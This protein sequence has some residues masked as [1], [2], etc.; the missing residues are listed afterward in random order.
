MPI[1]ELLLVWVDFFEAR[2]PYF[3]Q[4]PYPTTQ[5]L[6]VQIRAHVF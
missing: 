5:P 4:A 6:S 3:E 2:V 1:L